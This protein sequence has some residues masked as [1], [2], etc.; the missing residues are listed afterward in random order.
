MT[1]G[2]ARCRETLLAERH[3]RGA[4]PKHRTFLFAGDVCPAP[5]VTSG[6]TARLHCD[7]WPLRRA[8]AARSWEARAVPPARLTL[9]STA[10]DALSAPPL[11]TPRGAEAGTRAPASPQPCRRGGAQ[12]RGRPS[13]GVVPSAACVR[14]DSATCLG[15]TRSG[16]MSQ[17]PRGKAAPLLRSEAAEHSVPLGFRRVRSV[18]ASER[19]VHRKDNGADLGPEGAAGEGERASEERGRGRR[20]VLP[21]GRPHGRTEPSAAAGTASARGCDSWSLAV[22]VGDPESPRYRWL[23]R[24]A[25]EAGGQPRAPDSECVRCPASGHR[26][27]VW[28]GSPPR[29]PA[30]AAWGPAATSPQRTHACLG[31][32]LGWLGSRT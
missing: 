16:D 1:P 14:A 13:P 24:P 31:F 7:P 19:N 21:A 29:P 8:R 6:G 18:S 12:P 17:A 10:L 4:R 11:L 26:R 32:Q 20:S 5:P 28:R 27:T 2:P 15:A 30:S 3:S 25:R 23:W 22:G 9:L